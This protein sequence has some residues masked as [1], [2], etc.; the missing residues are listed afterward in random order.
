MDLLAEM[1]ALSD[2]N[3]IFPLKLRYYQQDYRIRTKI[4]LKIFMFKI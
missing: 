4:D 1:K 2:L 3:Q